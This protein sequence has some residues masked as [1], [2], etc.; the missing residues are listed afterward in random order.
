MVAYLPNP[1]S[2]LTEHRELIR[3]FQGK[4]LSSLMKESFATLAAMPPSTR[5]ALPPELGRFEA[6]IRRKPGDGGAVEI[7]VQVVKRILW[8]F[9]EGRSTGFEVFS[10]GRIV[11]FDSTVDGED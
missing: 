3:A 10:E 6:Y 9:L 4:T 2:P 8:I 7:S 1:M 5:V 11:P